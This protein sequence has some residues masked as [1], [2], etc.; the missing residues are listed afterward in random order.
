MAASEY[1]Q[2]VERRKEIAE[3]LIELGISLDHGIESGAQI[4]RE[5]TKAIDELGP[6]LAALATYQDELSRDAA[7]AME[8]LQP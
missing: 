1:E 3:R 8:D 2:L 4:H 6:L 5:L 7:A